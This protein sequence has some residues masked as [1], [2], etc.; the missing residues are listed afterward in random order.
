[1]FG[2]RF[3]QYGGAKNTRELLPKRGKTVENSGVV[4]LDQ[5]TGLGV[6]ELEAEEEEEEET[7]RPVPTDSNS[8]PQGLVPPAYFLLTLISCDNW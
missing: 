2:L 7:R 4:H 8:Y 1:M 5:L 6:R 3:D